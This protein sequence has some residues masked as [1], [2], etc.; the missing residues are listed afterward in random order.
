MSKVALSTPWV[1]YARMLYMLF[2]E[3]PDINIIY[4][5]DACEVRLYVS[6]S[7]KANALSKKLPTE[8]AFG[9]ITLKITVIPGNDEDSPIDIF[10]KI[11][12]GNPILSEILTE[13]NPMQIG[14]SHV[15]F[16][17]EVVQYFNDCLNDPMGLETTLYE[18]IA[19]EVFK[20][21]GTDG[22]FFNTDVADDSEIIIWP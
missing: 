3:D 21:M 6:N 7:E 1:S 18:D 4:D 10:R 12:T 11:F 15:I 19:R 9:N 16:R 20:D 8:K 14:M 2:G 22:V 13:D 5:N 17:N